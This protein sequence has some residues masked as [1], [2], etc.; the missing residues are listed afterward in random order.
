MT[1]AN[2]GSHLSPLIN[3]F[4]LLYSSSSRV[5]VAYSAF[6][7][8]TIAS[9]G[10]DSTL[11]NVSINP[12]GYVDAILPVAAIDAFGHIDIVASGATRAVLALFGLD[13]DGA[14]RADSLAK[15][16]SDATL[17]A[18]RVTAEGVLPTEAG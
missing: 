14:R 9:T 10:Q 5:S 6:G 4:S 16:T 7:L 17:F 2:S 18:G 3:N 8:S 11:W 12:T 15:L 1:A 13:G